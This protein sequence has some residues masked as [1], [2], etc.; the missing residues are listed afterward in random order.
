MSA[1]FTAPESENEALSDRN[2]GRGNVG[3]A[4]HA[5]LTRRQALQRLGVAGGLAGMAA[6]QAF[7]QSDR[8]IVLGQSAATSGAAAQL[9]IQL[10]L[11]ARLAFD[12]ANAA[13]GIG[14]RPIEL[15][16]VDDGYEPER[17]RANTENFIAQD[18]FALFGYVG[19]PTSLSVLPLVNKA[20]IPFFGPF[21]G[22]HALREPF[23][24][25]VFHVRCSYFDET[26]L[27]VRN[28]TRLGLKKIAV[29]R[30]ADSYGQAGLDGVQRALAARGLEPVVVGQ[31]ARNSVDVSAAVKAIVPRQ[32]DAV[33]QISAYKSCAAFIREARAVGYGG[34]FFNVSFVGTQALM[35]ELGRDAAG[36]M[37]TQVMPSPFSSAT[38]LA[39]EYLDAI[40]RA[41]NKQQPNYS[42]IEGY[43]A[44][45]VMIEGLK[46]SR[47]A[48]RD[49]LITALEA[50]RLDFGGMV[51]N[52]AA[53][54]HV[55]SQFVEMTLL[56]ADGKVRR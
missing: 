15:R 2:H 11:G 17:C 44:A 7:A 34:M 14:G 22:A 25:Q 16:L 29:F 56:T 27:I 10:N 1:A 48:S 41:G 8:P 31:V 47:A 19:T 37:V 18:V 6:P 36:V 35:D 12:A 4:G 53:H 43:L 9:G 55:G 13:G 42:G 28:L 39:R 40:A 24:R 21:T 50:L 52:F 5:A 49:A 54:S 26:E 32:P 3:A 46:R 33:I 30:Q 20:Q 45:R 51:V 38:G 23:S